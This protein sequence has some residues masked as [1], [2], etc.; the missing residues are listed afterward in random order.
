VVDGDRRRF[1]REACLL[2]VHLRV[3]TQIYEGTLVNISENG[4]YLAIRRSVAEGTEVQVRFRHPWTDAAVTGRAMVMRNVTP[5][6]AGA[7]GPGIGL[8]LLDTLSDLEGADV[9]SSGSFPQIPK[10]QVEALRAKAR[11][12]AALREIRRPVSQPSPKPVAQVAPEPRSID[13]PTRHAAPGLDVLFHASGR[14]NAMGTLSNISAGGL[15]VACDAPPEPG[16]LVR[17]EIVE[18]SGHPNLRLAGRV[19]WANEDPEGEQAR[20]FGVRILHFLSAADERRF[21]SFLI[22]LKEQGRVVGIDPAG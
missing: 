13:R 3:G 14:R 15:Q 5:G 8:A 16:R 22:E 19:T 18:G 7:S 1:A 9:I 12:T 20:G 17:L 2:T 6:T 21:A 10:D 4:A 11:D